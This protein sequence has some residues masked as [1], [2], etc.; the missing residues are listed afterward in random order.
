MVVGGALPRRR[1]PSRSFT[2]ANEIHIPV[3]RP[4]M[5]KLH[6]DRRDPQLLGP[7]PA[8][9]EGP[10]PRPRSTTLMP[11]GRPAGHAIAASAPSSAA[12]STRTWRS[13]VVAEP[14]RRLRR[15]AAHAAAPA[16]ARA[17]D[18]RS[19]RGPRG[20]PRAAPASLCH[21]IRGTTAPA[22]GRPRPH[23]CRAAGTTL[24][25]GHAAEHAAATSRGWIADPQRIKPGVEH[26]AIAARSRTS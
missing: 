7:E 4:V 1:T 20:V 24:A 18:D 21:A 2:T 15:L 5:V 23:P 12:C 8:R 3:G 10:D 9:Q 22:H 13:Y 14:P 19:Q 6:V 17:D 25:A 11:P 16:R 26:A